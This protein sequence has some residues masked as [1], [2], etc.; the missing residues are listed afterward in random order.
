MIINWSSSWFNHTK[1]VLLVNQKF[2]IQT[3]FVSLNPNEYNE[4]FQYYPFSVKLDKYTL[5]VVKLWMIYLIKHVSQI[6]QKI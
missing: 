6:K 2:E 1:C 3:T 4:Q 5:E